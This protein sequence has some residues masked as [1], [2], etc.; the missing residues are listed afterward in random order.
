MIVLLCIQVLRD[1]LPVGV[2]FQT[3]YQIRCDCSPEQSQ[4]TTN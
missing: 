1:A 4:K 3:G 2:I